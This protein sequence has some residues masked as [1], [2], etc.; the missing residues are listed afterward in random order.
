VEVYILLARLVINL[1][2]TM[3]MRFYR[4]EELPTTFTGD[5]GVALNSLVRDRDDITVDESVAPK[6]KRHPRN[7]K[8]TLRALDLRRLL[9][10]DFDEF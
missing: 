2:M 10:R 8:T 9:D 7:K 1:K 5:E 4:E 3:L 6:R